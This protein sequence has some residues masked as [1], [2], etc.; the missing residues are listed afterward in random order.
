M[1]ILDP[2]RAPEIHISWRYDLT[3]HGL[4]LPGHLD[5]QVQKLVTQA[6]YSEPSYQEAKG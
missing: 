6:I 4:M 2:A 5:S 3:H 1:Q